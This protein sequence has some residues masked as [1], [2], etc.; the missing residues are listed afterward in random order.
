MRDGQNTD[1][2]LKTG[3]LATD[4]T[5]IGTDFYQRRFLDRMAGWEIGEANGT[6]ARSPEFGP[7][8]R[9]P[10]HAGRV[11]SPKSERDGLQRDAED[12]DRDGRAPR[13]APLTASSDLCPTAL[14][15][16]RG[17][18]TLSRSRGRG[19]FSLSPVRLRPTSAFVRRLRRD[20]PAYFPNALLKLKSC[21]TLS[22]E[23]PERA[24]GTSRGFCSIPKLWPGHRTEDGIRRQAGI[25][26]QIDRQFAAS[27]V[28]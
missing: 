24:I 11:C 18:T 25:W 4:G 8:G 15:R 21:G 10:V 5:P 1:G 17:G 7:R 19:T 22:D 23:D 9:G 3:I 14:T 6:P 26:R 20:K 27:R 12:S 2:K 13:K 28:R 16:S